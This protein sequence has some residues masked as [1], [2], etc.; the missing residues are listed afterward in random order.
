MK[1]SAVAIAFPL[2]VMGS[3]MLSQAGLAQCANNPP[4][5]M[6]GFSSSTCFGNGT[7]VAANSSSIWNVAVGEAALTADTSGFGNTAVGA[8]ALYLNTT[9]DTNTAI[10]SG[11]MQ[12][13]I[14]GSSN[15]A[16]GYAALGQNSADGNTAVGFE[17]LTDNFYG[18][19]NTAIGDSALA[20]NSTGNNNVATGVGALFHNSTGSDNVATGFHSMFANTAGGSNVAEGSGALGDNATGSNN[21]ALG[22][23][24]LA[25]LTAGNTNLA[26]GSGAGTAYTGGESLNILL[27]NPGVAGESNVL[28]IGTRFQSKAF[29][30]GIYGATS[31]SGVP[32][33]VNS[34]G[35][36]GAATSS[37]RFKEDVAD[38]G[39]ASDALMRLRPVTFH[40]R[41][42]YDDGQRLLQYGL[43]AEEV[44]KVDPGLVEYDAD[45]K[46]FTVRY[47][48]VNAM[49]L[50]EVQK[51]H[52]TIAGQAARL[53]QQDADIAGQRSAMAALSQTLAALTDRLAHLEAAASVHP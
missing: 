36:L 24:A 20:L 11:A 4:I 32:V 12:E 46:P 37:L 26:L 10:G 29:V 27:A 19:Y 7:L 39:A 6:M 25:N 51:Q 35:Q 42:E 33:Y 48:F 52:A 18:A 38:M 3:M 47:Q 43:I 31:S 53:A 49:L 15:T 30:A 40:Y 50:G 5:G 9:G 2:I 1:T 16:L 44:A 17:T 45:G 13:N 41:A 23:N 14:T 34:S 8:L 21:S 28:R 22:L